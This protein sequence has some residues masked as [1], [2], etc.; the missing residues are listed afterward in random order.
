V[1]AHEPLGRG[2]LHRLVEPIAST[3]LLESGW[4][5]EL[6]LT[7][8]FTVPRDESGGLDTSTFDFPIVVPESESALL[9]GV[10]LAGLAVKESRRG[11]RPAQAPMWTDRPTDRSSCGL[12]RRL[13]PG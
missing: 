9:L 5:D 12:S 4:R 1:I 7:H 2:A 6:A 11:R 8:F 3:A 13:W 10:D